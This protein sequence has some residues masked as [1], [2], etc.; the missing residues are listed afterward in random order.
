MTTI[1]HTPQSP[2]VFLS[3]FKRFSMNY[4]DLVDPNSPNSWRNTLQAP[5]P[6]KQP[7]KR[8]SMNFQDVLT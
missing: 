7:S 6:K 4:Q 5:P 3:A 8:F 2:A 1:S